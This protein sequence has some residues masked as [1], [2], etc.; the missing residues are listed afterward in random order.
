[1][2]YSWIGKN[3]PCN[4]VLKSVRIPDYSLYSVAHT[5]SDHTEHAV[6]HWWRHLASDDHN[7]FMSSINQ[8]GKSSRVPAHEDD[9]RLLAPPETV[10]N[11]SSSVEREDW[12]ASSADRA[13]N[14]DSPPI[15]AMQSQAAHLWWHLATGDALTRFAKANML[16]TPY[17][18]TRVVLKR[19][20]TV[21]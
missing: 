11:L 15:A 21:C 8:I 13:V 1:M 6:T 2:I 17:I 14:V 10:A 19:P 7:S 18:D 20:H 5:P 3:L 16:T 9:R 12:W 4:L